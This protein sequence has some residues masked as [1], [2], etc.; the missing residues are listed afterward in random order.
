[1][2]SLDAFSPEAIGQLRRLGLL[3]QLLQRQAMAE[4]L[5]AVQLSDEEHDALR[6]ELLERL[7][8]ETGDALDDALK[9]KGLTEEDALWQASVTLRTERAA[10]EDY[11]AQTENHFLKRKLGLDRVVYRLLRVKDPGVCRELFLQV[12][13]GE[14]DFETL[15]RQYSEGPERSSGGVVGPAPMN[16][17]HPVL[18]EALRSSQPGELKGPMRLMDWWIIA[19]LE[20]VIPAQFDEEMRSR[21][22]V[23]LL[24]EAVDLEAA[25]RMRSLMEST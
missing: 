20:T 21:M 10:L 25:R 15:A 16:Q 7:K 9:S 24:Q 12:Q 14:A 18:S 4:R 22:A 13:S 19:R 1:M 8:L 17:A 23:E 11:G 5:E 6:L 2:P 3:G